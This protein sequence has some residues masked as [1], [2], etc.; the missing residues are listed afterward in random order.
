MV[1]AALKVLAPSLKALAQE[2][3]VSHAMARRYRT[4]DT[5]VPLRVRKR[6][7]A[8]LRLHAARLLKVAEQ[9]ERTEDTDRN[10]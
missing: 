7:V 2:L 1:S 8:I 4:G 6:L 10:P 9:I 3:R 5:A